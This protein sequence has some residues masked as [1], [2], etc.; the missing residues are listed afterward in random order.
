MAELEALSPD[1]GNPYFCQVSD[2]RAAQAFGD[3]R[4][5]PNGLIKLRLRGEHG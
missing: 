3:A 1:D 4:P 5:S 2:A